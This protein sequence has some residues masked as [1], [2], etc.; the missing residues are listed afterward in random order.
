M[1]SVV[2]EAKQVY[3][4]EVSASRRRDRPSSLNA[5]AERGMDILESASKAW[6]LYYLHSQ[7]KAHTIGF[8]ILKYVLVNNKRITGPQ[9]AVSPIQ[10]YGWPLPTEFNYLVVPTN[11]SLID[12]LTKPS[13]AQVDELH[14][15][16]A[17]MAQE[18]AP[19]E[20]LE[21]RVS[22]TRYDYQ[23]GIPGES[24]VE[25]PKDP[26]QANKAAQQSGEG[27]SIAEMVAEIWGDLPTEAWEKLPKDGA[28][29]YRHYLYGAPKRR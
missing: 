14:F 29:N 4:C 10:E 22:D 2:S 11:L 28:Y 24:V 12:D 1:K 7:P 17:S 6:R 16:T 13:A 5:K 26:A 20:N 19:K 9:V 3:D 8:Y 25:Q 27:K 18:N 15:E 23:H 21:D